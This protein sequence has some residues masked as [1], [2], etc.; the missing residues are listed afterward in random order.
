MSCFDW[1]RLLLISTVAS[2]FVDTNW[3]ALQ[4]S[5][6]GAFLVQ[7]DLSSSIPVD[8]IT[9]V[10]VSLNEL[11]FNRVGYTWQ[12]LRI[13]LDLLPQLVGVISMN[14]YW[15]LFT[16]KWQIC[17][18]PIA[19]NATIDSQNITQVSWNGLLYNCL[20]DMSPADVFSIAA[21]FLSQTNTEF[22]ANILQFALVPYNILLSHTAVMLRNSLLHTPI[23]YNTTF[24]ASGVSSLTDIILL[25]M[26]YLY[27]PSYLKSASTSSP[28][29]N[30]SLSYGSAYPTRS[31]FLFRLSVRLIAYVL[32]GQPGTIPAEKL[33]DVDEEVFFISGSDLFHPLVYHLGGDNLLNSLNRTTNNSFTSE[34][35]WNMAH[36]S[37]FRLVYDSEDTPFTNDSLLLVAQNGF[38][39][40]VN[41]TSFV[42]VS[43]GDDDSG[44][45]SAMDSIIPNSFWSWAPGQPL[46]NGTDSTD[47]TRKDTSDNDN[48]LWAVFSETQVAMRCVT[49][50]GNGWNLDNCYN[51]Y[52]CACQNLTDPFSWTLSEKIKTY[53]ATASGVTCPEGFQ[54]S[55]PKLSLEQ[56]SLHSLLQRFNAQYPVWIDVNDIYF[57][58]CFVTGGPYTECPHQKVLTTT[59]LIKRVAPS[60]VVSLVV[61]ILI[62]SAHV[63][64]RSPIQSN[65]T[66]HWKKAIAEYYKE[67]DFEGVP[68]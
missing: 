66:R 51:Q 57:P 26:N 42:T 56:S 55:A 52:R 35:F 67:N 65:R 2:A 58:Q 23:N 6:A 37:S 12:S 31:T 10:G 20:V 4:A 28:G 53:F 9:S 47:L 39:P 60:L 68:S 14:V 50:Q 18:A 45:L 63:F 38:T 61:V 44:I 27:L 16:Q 11:V 8:Q 36:R 21:N 41:S 43:P 49:I 62:V 29:S 33:P 7:R 22:Q 13:L 59:S 64:T 17:P 5:Y 25:C 24:A 46:V 1:F 15:N 3:T 40:I 30:Q 54:F 48:P 34:R 19:I 32:S